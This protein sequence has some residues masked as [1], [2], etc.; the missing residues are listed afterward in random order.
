MFRGNHP[1]EVVNVQT[2]VVPAKVVECT[3]DCNPCRGCECTNSC[4]KPCQGCEC[5]NSCNPCEDCGI[6]IPIPPEPE[7]PPYIFNRPVPEQEEHEDNIRT[8]PT[9]PKEVAGTVTTFEDPGG[10]GSFTLT[11][12]KFQETVDTNVVLE[13]SGRD[14]FPGTTNPNAWTEGAGIEAERGAQEPTKRVTV[15]TDGT[16]MEESWDKEKE[17]W[18][19]T[20]NLGNIDP[21]TKGTAIEKW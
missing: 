12:N 16:Q 21:N 1:A 9:E 8:E 4:N 10:A 7:R 19:S 17:E 13:G 20:G 14:P 11:A 5:T 6:P 18:V 3:G 15:F 2:A